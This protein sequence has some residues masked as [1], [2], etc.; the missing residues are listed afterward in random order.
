MSES[1]HSKTVAGGWLLHYSDDN[2]YKAISSQPDWTFK[3][4][5]PPGDNEAGAYFTTLPPDAHR[6]SA[7][8]KIP[9]AK[10]KNAFAFV[11][12]KRAT[13]EIISFGRRMI[14]WS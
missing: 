13:K 9:Q 14:I 5:Q 3:S 12:Q 10:Q 4:S 11:G 8:T 1:K 6:F 2:G 7:Q